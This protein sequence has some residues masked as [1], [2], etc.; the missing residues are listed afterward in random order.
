[1]ENRKEATIYYSK[2]IEKIQENVKHLE[3]ELIRYKDTYKI[4]KGIRKNLADRKEDLKYYQNLL[5][6][7][8]EEGWAE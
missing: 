3:K 4:A 8:K 6:E 1:M 2:I 5:E 7:Y